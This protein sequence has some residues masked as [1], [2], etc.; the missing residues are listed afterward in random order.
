MIYFFPPG[1]LKVAWCCRVPERV[2]SPPR[3][4]T[5]SLL[6]QFPV[7]CSTLWGR[8][9]SASLWTSTVSHT[10]L[11]T[12]CSVTTCPHH[13]LLSGVKGMKHTVVVFFFFFFF[14]PLWAPSP[15]SSSFLRCINAQTQQ[16][17]IIRLFLCLQSVRFCWWSLSQK[18]LMSNLMS[19]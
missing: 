12:P 6:S 11:L 18:Q 13:L 5:P 15:S 2:C 10:A 4:I 17:I 14:F 8:P 19:L 1:G 9:M 3:Q 7:W 16:L